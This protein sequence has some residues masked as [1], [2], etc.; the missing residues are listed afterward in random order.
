MKKRHSSLLFLSTLASY[1]IRTFSFF[2]LL[3]I[4][5]A[6]QHGNGSDH[7]GSP[8][9]SDIHAHKQTLDLDP[10]LTDQAPATE[11]NDISELFLLIPDEYLLT[12]SDR[13]RKITAEERKAILAGESV[14]RK[15][16]RL[17]T[18]G[19][20]LR[21]VKVEEGGSHFTEITYFKNTQKNQLVG[22][23]HYWKGNV[24]VT[25]DI[26]FI[27]KTHNLW[28]DRTDG[29]IPLTTVKDFIPPRARDGLSSDLERMKSSAPASVAESLSK[30]YF[31]LYQL[32]EVGKDLKVGCGRIIDTRLK[33][34]LESGLAKSSEVLVYSWM[35]GVF[36]TQ[37][38]QVL[39]RILEVPNALLT[40]ATRSGDPKPIIPENKDSPANRMRLID[41]NDA[42]M[43]K[44]VIGSHPDILV[45]EGKAKVA[46]FTPSGFEKGFMGVWVSRGMGYPNTLYFLTPTDDGWEDITHDV[47]SSVDQ[48]TIDE[49]LAKLEPKW[50]STD[51]VGVDQ[52][53]YDLIP[54]QNRIH[55]LYPAELWNGEMAPVL[56]DLKWNQGKFKPF[57]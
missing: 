11:L 13:T 47:M 9:S 55:V 19:G 41:Q 15:L 25:T 2:V 28:I 36:N 48:E 10:N 54:A 1:P 31:L 14:T 53:E 27:E 29:V 43:E 45:R 39:S 51:G 3:N 24:E 40:M 46:W 44:A 16:E 12:N 20:Y 17:N 30:E 49:S 56:I 37:E 7:P 32:P 57:P 38:G 35:N 23:N 33:A 8:L 22:I 34:K 6:C 26:Y 5:Y 50:V 4:C 52:L 18:S 42:W 21:Y